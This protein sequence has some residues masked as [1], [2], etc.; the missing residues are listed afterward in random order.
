[1]KKDNINLLENYL[2]TEKRRKNTSSK[3]L[4]FIAIF[5]I[6]I[7][8]ISAYSL[9][10]FL[11]DQGLKDSNQQL[12]AYV[13]DPN[14][15]KQVSD[16]AVKQRQ[17]ADL[18]EI[19]NTIKSLNAAFDA[20]PELDSIVLDKINSCIPA[21]TKITSIDYDGQWL[22]LKTVST[23][24]LRP[25]EFARSLRNT[26]FFEDTIYYG[27]EESSGKYVGTVLVAL[28]VGK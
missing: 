12:N 16:V 9:K 3:G 17:L 2:L 28:K 7:I 26:N 4:N 27:Y 10:L 14:I 24:Y 18:K 11:E 6:T 21:D 13:T 22:T 23:N 19:L 20:M 15:I 5:L 25:S 1:M 8:L